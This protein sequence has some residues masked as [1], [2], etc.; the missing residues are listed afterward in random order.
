MIDKPGFA[1]RT[2]VITGTSTGIGRACALHLD[3]LGFH[4]FAGV[5]TSRDAESLHRESA[6]RITP[7]L[8]DVTDNLSVRAAADAVTGA[9][10]DAG[11]F[12]LVN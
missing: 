7:L 9:A 2:V 4:V 11:L 6:R 10:G 5:R 3:G 1:G 8:M 12:G